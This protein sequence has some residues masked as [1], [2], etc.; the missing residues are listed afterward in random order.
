MDQER[1]KWQALRDEYAENVGKSVVARLETRG[2]KARYAATAEEARQ[3]L[4]S[5]IP[6]EAS[7]G[8][9]G[10]ATVRELGLMEALAKRGNRIYQHWDPA[11]KA[12][13]K[14]GRLKDELN[15]DVFLSGS[16]AVT[17]DGTIVNIDGTGNRVAGLAWGDNRLIIVVGV[18]KICRDVES[19]LV[20]VRD[21]ATPPNTQR[22][23]MTTPCATTGFCSDCNS[24]QRA[25][26][27]VLIL[28]RAPFGRDAHVIVVGETLGF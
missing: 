20:R 1:E 15:S 27:A 19:A 7:V 21:V 4:F 25:C 23:K 17:L 12:E 22:L 26:R 10:S 2:Y 9:P 16:N 11:L 24:P 18:N 14:A 13:E 6:E 28:E 3:I 8:I 5:L